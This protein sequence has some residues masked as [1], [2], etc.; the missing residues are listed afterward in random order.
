MIGQLCRMLD[1][2]RGSVIGQLC[3]MLDDLRGSA[4]PQEDCLS[5]LYTTL[6]GLNTHIKD[7]RHTHT[8]RTEDTHTHTHTH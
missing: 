5:S 8:Q 6:T 2:L 3:K 7:R 1:D 4:F